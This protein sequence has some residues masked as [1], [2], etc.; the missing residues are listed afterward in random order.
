MTPEETVKAQTKRHIFFPL[1]L[2]TCT[3]LIYIRTMA[4]SVMHIDGGELAAVQSLL[5]IAHP[6]GYPL[7]TLT[8]YL[9]LR[10]PLFKSAVYQS[11]FLSMIWC[12]TGLIFIM[13][14]LV[15]LL[16]QQ[17]VLINPTGK[18]KQHRT[19]QSVTGLSENML[20]FLAALPAAFYLAFSRTFWQQGTAVEV[21]SLHIALTGFVLYYALRAYFYP[22]TSWH[23]WIWVSVAMALVLT[24]HMTGILII[25]GLIYLFIQKERLS[26]GTVKK[27]LILCGLFIIIW[28]SI[29]L[30][31]PLRAA[32]IPVLNWG[33]PNSWSSLV[34][35]ISGAQYRVWLFS[36]SGAAARNIASFLNGFPSEFFWIGLVAGCFGLIVCI[37]QAPV[38]A[39]FTSLTFLLNILYAVNYDIHDLDSYFLLAYMVFTIW[40]AYGFH[41]ILRRIGRRIYQWAVFA[42]LLLTAIP[43]LL[44]NYKENDRSHCYLY[45]DYTREFLA[46]LDTGSILLSYQW[47]Y[48]ISPSYY[49]QFVEGYRKDI[50]VIDKELLR[51]S[52]YYSQLEHNYPHIMTS[53]GKEAEQFRKAVAPFE[54]GETYDTRTLEFWYREVFT[55]LIEKGF[56]SGRTVYIAPELVENELRQGNL[57]LPDGVLL[58]PDLF[59]FRVVDRKEYR[60]LHNYEINIRFPK[61]E[62]KYT[63]GVKGLI[64]KSLV[65]RALY[66]L[67]H[68]QP[69]RVKQLK[70]SL[71]SIFP[72]MVLP[73]K[74]QNESHSLR[75]P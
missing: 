9:F 67:E 31:L 17:K 36:S 33:N 71:T 6:T 52:W 68:D 11:N 24:N 27:S 29:L 28:G 47:D 21:Y 51:R 12:V 70:R 41:G 60:P 62:D 20:T 72:E 39:I 45:E 30:Y 4:P 37:L 61:K 22:G 74:L 8:G 32:Q 46:S 16:S 26:A 15:L 19:V 42:L 49:F 38:I 63:K 10:I 54:A 7:F 25:P 5:G 23:P 13:K 3:I 57:S 18:H 53:I 1:A 56:Q 69:L 64:F 50:A 55:Q 14:T 73:R 43:S 35:H 2:L 59:Y 66:E 58:V 65:W 48:L 75:Y 34:R 44:M 40:I